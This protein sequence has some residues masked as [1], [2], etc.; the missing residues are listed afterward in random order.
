MSHNRIDIT[1]EKFGKLKAISFTPGTKDKPGRWLCQCDCGKTT[2]ATAGALRARQRTSCGCSK[3]NA[4]S[5]HIAKDAVD[6]TRR[7]ALK[8]KLHKNNKSGVKGVTYLKD[9]QKWLAYIGFQNKTKTLGYFKDKDDAIA[10]R[11]KAEQELHGP[12]KNT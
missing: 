2:Y 5:K 10:A 4:T 6:G 12:Y 1:D 8:S 11:K 7:S 9:R 3:S